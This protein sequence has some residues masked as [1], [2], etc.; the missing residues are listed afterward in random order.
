MN[1]TLPTR[2]LPVVV[3]DDP[4]AAGPLADAI[5]AGG[6]RVA[7]VT[8][9]NAAA[10]QV[11]R[12]MASRP[13]LVVGAGTVI[14]PDQVDEA[15]SAGATFIVSPGLSVP[16][17]ER[18]RQLGLLVIPGVATATEM[19]VAVNMGLRLVKFFPAES[20]GGA[21]AVKALSAPFPSMRFVPTGGIDVEEL[22]HYL[23]VPSVAAV[24]GS[25]MVAPSLVRARKFDEITKLTAEAVRI[26]ESATAAG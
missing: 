20:A 6:L 13:E 2:L 25:W 17:I 3:L 18:A 19:M 14:D 15:R 1:D 16:V 8:F 21:A 23:S 11:L 24:G 9:R 5:L 10:P 22:P 7:E 26:C 4:G 12:E